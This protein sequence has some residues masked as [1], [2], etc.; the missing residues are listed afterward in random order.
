[1]DE[2]LRSSHA[3]DSN[4]FGELRTEMLP[5][6]PIGTNHLLDIGCGTGAFGSLVKS[7]IGA[8]VWGI[9][10]VEESAKIAQGVLDKV[11][12]GG[13]NVM[14][15]TVPDHYFDCISCNDVLEHLVAPDSL[16][17]SLKSKLTDTGVI[18]SSI[19]NV[20]YWDNLKNL[21]LRKQW[22]Y[23][24]DG[25]LDRTH[26]RF[27]TELSI[28]NMFSSLSFEIVRIDGINPSHSKNLKLFNFLTLGALKDAKYLQFACVIRPKII[29]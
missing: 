3:G 11:I 8:E 5:Y 7:Q 23:Q 13:A 24:D 27:F 12:I 2:L 6:V 28:R 20:R 15:D 17:A 10:L 29:S 9:E 25:I 26:L 22:E 1:M 14:V 4:Y 18:I 16:L 19:P 21:L